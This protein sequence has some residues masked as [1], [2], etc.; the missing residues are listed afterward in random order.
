MPGEVIVDVDAAFG[1]GDGG[2]G[3]ALEQADRR[4]RDGVVIR[5][6]NSS[7]GG[8]EALQDEGFGEWPCPR[9]VDTGLCG[10]LKVRGLV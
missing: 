10:L 4:L 3:F 2:E 8:G 5:V 1:A 7:D 6:A 9:F